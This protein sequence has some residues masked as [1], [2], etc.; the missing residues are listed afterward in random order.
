MIVCR[1]GLDDKYQGRYKNMEI[2]AENAKEGNL[3]YDKE[4]S[5]SK[6]LAY[7]VFTAQ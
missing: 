1:A 2:W 7:D 5:F 4:K 6:Q 3:N